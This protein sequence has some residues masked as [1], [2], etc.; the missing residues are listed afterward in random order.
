MASHSPDRQKVFVV[1]GRNALA[2]DAT[3]QFLRALNL[4]PIEWGQAVAM[5]GKGAPYIGEI[6]DAAFAAAQAVVVLMTPDEVAYLRTELANGAHDP[7]LQPSAQARPNVLFEAGMALGRA[8]TRTILVEFGKVRPFSDVAGRHAI[9]LDGSVERRRELAQRLESAGCEVDITG[10]DWLSAGDLAP[11]Q[12]PGSG[13]PLGKR[14]PR[15]G[16]PARTGVD[17]RYH[18]GSGSHAGRLEIINRGTADL[19]QLDLEIPPEAGPF[20]IYSDELPLKR[21]PAGKSASL[22][23]D[24]S[25]GQGK[26]HF[27]VRVTAQTAKGVAVVEEVFLSTG[28]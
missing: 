27:D 25:W 5:T 3:F 6:L 8:P 1:Y 14:V 26:D 28:G 15:S 13:L 12:P 18:S 20:H 4:Q 21:L 19:F 22:V 24:R 10:T 16:G 17:L 7:D 23:A 9:H 11:P 2:R